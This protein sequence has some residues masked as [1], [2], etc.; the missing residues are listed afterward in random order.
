LA[1]TFFGNVQAPGGNDVILAGAGNDEVLPGP[2]NDIVD[3]GS[4][5]DFLARFAAGGGR[6]VLTWWDS[7]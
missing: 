6:L 3:G 1:T 7:P 4:G 5:D 2:G